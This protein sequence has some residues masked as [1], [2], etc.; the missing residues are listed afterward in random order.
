MPPKVPAALPRHRPGAGF[1]ERS[2][3]GRDSSSRTVEIP[4]SRRITPTERGNLGSEV[5]VEVLPKLQ[6]ART[7]HSPLSWTLELHTPGRAGIVT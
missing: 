5:Q 7:A 3:D 1:D 6:D 4:S 2:T